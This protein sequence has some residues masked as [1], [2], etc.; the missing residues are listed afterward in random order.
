VTALPTPYLRA[1]QALA[2]KSGRTIVISGPPLS[3]KSALLNEMRG[4]AKERGARIVELR[5]SYRARSV[6]YGALDGLSP[7]VVVPAPILGEPNAD[8]G[9]AGSEV[10]GPAPDVPMAPIAYLPDRLPRS[11]RSRGERA[12]TSFLGQP[13]RERSANEGDPEAYWQRLLAEFRGTDAHPVVILIEDGALFDSE[14]REFVVAL[15][16]KARLRPLLIVCAL[17]TTAPGYVAWEDVFLGRGDVDWVRIPDPLPDAREAHRLKGIFDDLPSVTQRVVGYVALLRG[18]VGEVVL[19]RVARLN[20]PQLA[21][22]LLPAS[23]VGVVKVQ[24]GKVIVP[25]VA[26]VNLIADLLPEKQLREMHLE[27]ANA[28][29]AL[30]PEPTLAR[31]IEVA[32]HYL[33][34]FPGPM[35]LRHLLEAGELS[36]HLLSFDTA[37]ELFADALASVGSLPPAERAAIEP[38]LRLLHAQALFFSGRLSEAETELREGIATALRAKVAVE[39]V[40]EWIEPLLLAMRVIGPLGSMRMTLAEL[41]DRCHDAR[42]TEIEILIQSLIAEFDW[43]RN[44]PDRARDESRRAAA[45][46]QGLPPGHLQA[47][48][49]LAVG[50]ARIEGSPEEQ[51]VAGRF[52]Q[53]ARVLFGRTRRWELDH[54]AGDLEARLLEARGEE[55][56]ALLL[57]QQAIPALQRQKL[58]AV[59]IYHQ[60]AIAESLL[61]RR[62]ANGVGPALERARA[63]TETLHLVPPSPCL[64]HLW[65]LE[66][67]Q[68]ALNEETTA[69]RDRWEALVEETAVEGIPRYRTE[70]LLRL[71]LL[72]FSSGRADVA[73]EHVRRLQEPE[74]L[75]ALPAAYRAGLSDLARVAPESE[76]GGGPLPVGGSAKRRD[77][78]KGER[79]R[80]EPVRNRQRADGQ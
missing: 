2:E 21:E 31:R 10:V 59:E 4:L 41:A 34:W 35:A 53:A 80:R 75:E 72:E 6:P 42:W 48:A 63:I 73:A 52:L 39:V 68:Q 44:E 1:M 79:S 18:N 9:L 3:G 28:L 36:L 50:L 20:Y 15:S 61:D 22:A 49:L 19:S 16:K 58:L 46:A 78:Q 47:I 45:L 27:I 56:R 23:G 5:G 60:L 11:R 8:V 24:E 40:A 7:E 55:T 14:S 25:H 33:A 67:R 76:H 64:L 13:V 32:R 54:M 57:R 37:E 71:A 66:G 77:G 65:L 30:S 38:E 62:V 12:R 17:D 51:E 43:E 70:A 74:L 29:A 26:W 69:A